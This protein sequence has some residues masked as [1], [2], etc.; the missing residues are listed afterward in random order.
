M[1]VLQRLQRAAWG[2]ENT[3]SADSLMHTIIIF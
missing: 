3:R 1:G 2:Q